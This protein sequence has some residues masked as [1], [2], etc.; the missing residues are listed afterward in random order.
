MHDK[1]ERRGIPL[2]PLTTP[3]IFDEDAYL[4]GNPDVATAVENKQFKSGKHH[5]SNFGFK[6]NRRQEQ[7]FSKVFKAMKN[8]K[9]GRIK[10]ILRRDQACVKKD[11]CFDFLT[12]ELA[13]KFSIIDTDAVSSN[14]YD[15]FA[16]G[17]IDKHRG[18][19]ILDCGAGS[20]STYYRDVV[21]FEI[22]EYPTT[23]VRGVGEVL[24]FVDNS[25]DAVLSLAVLEHVKDPFACAREIMRVLKPGGDLMACVPLL[26]PVHGYPNHF[27]NM[28]AQGLK[29][30][31]AERIEVERHEVIASGLPIWSLTWIAQ[32]W[33]AG[34]EGEAK[35]EFL[36]LKMSELM[37]TGEEYLERRFVKEL[38]NEKNFEL[39]S[40]TVLF[41]RKTA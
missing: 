39:A 7:I 18:G 41:G 31:F 33:A 10:R 4:A 28:T 3:E 6:E 11:G 40:T 21:N 22:V 16:L 17:L 29:N 9:L 8:E 24:P 25:F 36:D 35:Q 12:A 19:L 38:P 34:L 32:S 5:F 27:Y 20:Q 37:G 13:Q 26:Q 2:T 23:D 1:T 30:L 15:D 14:L